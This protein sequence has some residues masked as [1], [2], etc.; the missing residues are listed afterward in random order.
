[1]QKVSPEQHHF[2]TSDFN[3]WNLYVEYR[4]W[5]FQSSLQYTSYTDTWIIGR[6]SG[7][8]K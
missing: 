3:S 2:K 8:C 7:T 1:M 6:Y 5:S 4:E